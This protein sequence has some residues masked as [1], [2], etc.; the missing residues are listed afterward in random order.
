MLLLL[1]SGLWCSVWFDP[2][3][4]AVACQVPRS[5]NGARLDDLAV[6]CGPGDGAYSA[7]AGGVPPDA[8]RPTGQLTPVLWSGQ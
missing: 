7:C 6:E 1:R 2:A 8:N 3:L 5:Q 4:P